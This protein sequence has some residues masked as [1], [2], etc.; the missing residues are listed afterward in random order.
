[1]NLKRGGWVGRLSKEQDWGRGFT[2]D[3]VTGAA[4]REGQGV[5]SEE[6]LDSIAQYEA[7]K[8]GA[9]F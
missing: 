7:G 2:L 1:V 6:A 5:D 4:A 8:I 3:V 9:K